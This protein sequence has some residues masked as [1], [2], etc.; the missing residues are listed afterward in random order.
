[1]TDKKARHE[2]RKLAVK[3]LF[4]YLERE[5]KIEAQECLN[6]ITKE[7]DER[8][9]K[10][11]F[12]ELILGSAVEHIKK[13]KVL[14]RSYA[15]EFAFEKIAPIN[16]VVLI[17]GMAEM[18]YIK[19]PPI[20]VINEYIELAKEFG[21]SKSAPFINAVLDAFRKNSITEETEDQTK[22]SS[23]E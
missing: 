18:K 10:D 16:R 21:E 8:K 1:M 12:A 5:E 15:S 17:L 7:V 14:I 22:S 20:V 11:E 2:S 23:K 19:T 9:G 4:N 6:Y 3:A 13:I